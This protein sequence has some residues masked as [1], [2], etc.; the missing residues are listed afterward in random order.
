[1][2]L[3]LFLCENCAMMNKHIHRMPPKMIEFTYFITVELPVQVFQ[4]HTLP[5]TKMTIDQNDVN[6]N[7][8]FTLTIAKTTKRHD[9]K[10]K[11]KLG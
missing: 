11:N 4:F 5:N 3:T 2:Q 10:E 6:S 9:N 8:K 1:M 7:F